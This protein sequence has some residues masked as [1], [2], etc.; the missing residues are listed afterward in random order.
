[1]EVKEPYPKYWIRPS[2]HQTEAGLLPLDWSAA[3]LSDLLSSKQLGGNYKNGAA[4]TAWPL[5]KMGN[6]GR[7]RIDCKKV[8]YIHSSASPAARDR[9]QT[10]DVLFNTRNTLELVGKVAI[11]RDELPEAYFN[12][13][14]MR[15]GFDAGRVGSN[16]YMNYVL[17]T[18]RSISAFRSIATGTTS[19]AAIYGRDFQNVYLPL[20]SSQTEQRDIAEALADTDALIESLEQ[21]LTKKRQ[22]KQGAMQELLTGKRRLPGFSDSWISCTWGDVIDDCSSG[23]TPLRSHPEYYRGS[24]RWISS[25][26]LNCNVI[27]ETIEHISTEA[28][29]KTNLKLHPAGTFLMAITGLEAAGTRGACG[30]VGKSAATNQSCMA[31]YPSSKLLTAYLFHYYIFKG[32]ELALRFCQ[33]TKQQSYTAALI[34]VLPIVFPESTEEQQAIAQVLS[35][36][37]AE[38]TALEAR[39]T[40]ARALKQAMAQALLTGRIRLPVAS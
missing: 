40:K 31:I 3:A 27:D 13:N 35:D 28:L 2:T 11:W 9:L 36:M 23:A 19:V 5:I 18:S 4:E 7:G 22:I 39:L 14:I 1:M 10:G 32:D 30:I 29:E 37:D 20:P 17:N 25:G 15:M 24:I 8:E 21:L 38:I 16:A 33:G 6:L 34:R 26:E 12:S